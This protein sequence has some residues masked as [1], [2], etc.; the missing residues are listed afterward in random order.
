MSILARIRAHGG[1][2]VRVGWCMTL[3]PGR[4]GSDAIAWLKRD[5]VKARLHEE[6][7]PEVGDWHERAAIREFD[8]GQERATAEVEAFREVNARV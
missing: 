3:R 4:L 7:W 8:G 5:D 2:V 6:V 1:D